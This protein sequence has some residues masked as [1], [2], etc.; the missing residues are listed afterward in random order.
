MK[1]PKEVKYYTIAEIAFMLGIS[2]KSAKNPRKIR[3]IE[4]PHF[5]TTCRAHHIQGDS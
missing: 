5:L 4:I 2:E 1:L 3:R